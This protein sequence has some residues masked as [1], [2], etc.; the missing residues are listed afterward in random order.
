M[1]MA[2][3]GA[4]F[5]DGARLKILWNTVTSGLHL[6]SVTQAPL[7]GSTFKPLTPPGEN[8]GLHFRAARAALPQIRVETLIGSQANYEIKRISFYQIML[9][10]KNY[11][12]LNLH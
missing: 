6:A 7:G 2:C 3:A 8:M 5:N 11:S 1:V 10:S 9:Y 12:K 4:T